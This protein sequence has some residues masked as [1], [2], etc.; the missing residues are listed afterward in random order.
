M[1]EKLTV[2]HVADAMKDIDIAILSTH[3]PGD[4]ITSRPMSNNRDVRFD[5]TSYYFS[6]EDAQCVKDIARKKQER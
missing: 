6:Q 2:E 3:S 4:V 5:G 1:A